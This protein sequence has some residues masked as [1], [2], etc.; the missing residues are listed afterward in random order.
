MLRR[1]PPAARR[2]AALRGP[3]L[4][5]H[6]RSP[7]PGPA[8]SETPAVLPLRTLSGPYLVRT[9]YYLRTADGAICAGQV[10]QGRC[11]LLFTSPAAAVAFA[12]SSGVETASPLIFSRSRSEF[13]SQAGRCLGQGYIGGLIDPRG[14]TG[15]TAFLGFTVAC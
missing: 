2:R 6:P 9:L 13:L 7:R 3:L 14:G 11:L 15:R 10:W 12:E 8:H 4:C 1:Q 5:R